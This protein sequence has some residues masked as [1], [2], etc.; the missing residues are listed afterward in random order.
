MKLFFCISLFSFLLSPA[1][2]GE[3]NPLPRFVSLRSNEVNA[4]VGPGPGYPIDWVYIKTGLPVEV[5]VEFDTW[6]KIRDVDGAEGWVHQS[7]LCS[8]RHVIIQGDEALLYKD[9]DTQSQPLVRV[10]N[11]IV[12]DLLR[13][14]EKWCL[15][16]ILN[17]KGWIQRA[18]LWGI[19]PEENLK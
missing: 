5:I 8:K 16:R 13:C 18:S 3:K 17:F 7:M 14:Q 9:A 4:R 2:G 11:G 6:R 1:Y 19:Y 15:V 10:E 12:A